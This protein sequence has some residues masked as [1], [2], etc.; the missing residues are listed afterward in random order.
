M[1]SQEEIQQAFQD[2]QNGEFESWN[3]ILKTDA[4]F[5]GLVHLLDRAKPIF[6]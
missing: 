6:I 4:T 2:Y 3:E 5:S 1:N